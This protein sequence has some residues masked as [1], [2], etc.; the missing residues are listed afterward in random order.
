MEVS[1]EPC[2]DINVEG[3]PQLLGE[4]RGDVLDSSGPVCRHEGQ[5]DTLDEE[6]ASKREDV[7]MA[8]TAELSRD[9][10][11]EEWPGGGFES[12]YVVCR[13]SGADQMLCRSEVSGGECP[14]E[15]SGADN[16]AR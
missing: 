6:P 8:S 3:V 12:F 5:G 16:Q 7:K 11:K 1:C 14:C 13:L 9:V 10:S 15:I 2:R 4:C